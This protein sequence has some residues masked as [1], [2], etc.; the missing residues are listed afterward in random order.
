MEAKTYKIKTLNQL[1]NLANPE[2]IE[3]LS[4]DFALYLGYYV[5]VI[6]E[7]KKNH[8]EFKNKTNTKIIKSHFN[9]VDDGK[10][11]L[12]GVDLTNTNTGEKTYI[13]FKK[14][15]TNPNKTA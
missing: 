13:D 14:D 11:D 15:E 4:I 5:S 2:N 6:E 3:R 9:W 1:L 10:N 12:L 8:P 7:F